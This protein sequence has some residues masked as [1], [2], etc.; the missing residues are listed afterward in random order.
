MNDV[1]SAP[2]GYF[3]NEQ[4]DISRILSILDVG[5]VSQTVRSGNEPYKKSKNLTSGRFNAI[6]NWTSWIPT[7]GSRYSL[8]F[9]PSSWQ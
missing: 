5:T 1:P 8:R 9:W 2:I 3:E 7:V 6:S 4:R